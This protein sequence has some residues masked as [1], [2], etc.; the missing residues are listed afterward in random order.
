MTQADDIAAIEAFEKERQ[1]ALVTAD[2]EA[3]RR[4]LAEDLIHVHSTS[5][6]H[7][8]DELIAHVSR[9]GGFISIDRGPLDIRVEGDYALVTGRTINRVRSPQTGEEKRLEGFSTLV[10]RRSPGGWQIVL[11]QLTPDRPHS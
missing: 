1:R 6:V 4:I 3:L 5:M 2:G 7:G 8:K 11:S 10:L 9:M